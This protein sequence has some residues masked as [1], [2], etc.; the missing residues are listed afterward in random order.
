MKRIIA[1]PIVWLLYGLGHIAYLLTHIKLPTGMAYQKL[2]QW[3]GEIE[4]WA[5]A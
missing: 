4:D 2:M 1:L 5:K 3:S